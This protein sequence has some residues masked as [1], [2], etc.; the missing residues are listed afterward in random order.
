MGK[1]LNSLFESRITLKPKLGEGITGKESY[2]PA[3]L[4][5]RDSEIFN[6]T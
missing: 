1:F 3:P 5:K 6:K 2:R 4:L